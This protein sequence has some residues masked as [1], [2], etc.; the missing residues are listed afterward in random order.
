M[1]E[2]KSSSSY[3][4]PD[5][6]DV[7]EVSNDAFYEELLQSC[8]RKLEAIEKN[9]DEEKELRYS[10][11]GIALPETEEKAR[12]LEVRGIARYHL[13]DKA[14]TRASKVQAQALQDLQ[15]AKALKH[16]VPEA[17]G[18]LEKLEAAQLAGQDFPENPVAAGPETN[19]SEL[20]AAKPSAVN[21]ATA[22]KPSHASAAMASK[23]ADTPAATASKP[24]MTNTETCRDTAPPAIKAAV[25]E[26]AA[27]S[28]T[29]TILESKPS[30]DDTATSKPSGAKASESWLDVDLQHSDKGTVIFAS[31]AEGVEVDMADGTVRFSK[32]DK[33][34]DVPVRGI[35]TGVRRKRGRLEVSIAKPEGH[36]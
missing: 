33:T 23:L 14:G 1:P 36:H 29:Q 10:M 18:L 4:F 20:P 28:V 8:T 32:G 11:L 13:A 25:G 17:A 21:D 34:L 27:V 22:S 24:S 3:R 19:V 31:P 15:E 6:P 7:P 2:K 35:V 30:V 9:R 26:P 5:C 12:N 16:L